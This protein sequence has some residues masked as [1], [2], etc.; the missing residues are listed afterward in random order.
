MVAV[1]TT[2]HVD[3]GVGELRNHRLYCLELEKAELDGSFVAK[4]VASVVLGHV[5]A[6]VQQRSRAPRW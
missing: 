3:L 2:L 6:R 1:P 5:T 4:L